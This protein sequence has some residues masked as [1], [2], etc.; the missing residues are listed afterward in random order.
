MVCLF[1]EIFKVRRLLALA[2]GHEKALW[3]DLV[4]LVSNLNVGAVFK[5]GEFVPLRRHC[6]GIAAVAARHRPGPRERMVGGRDLIMQDVRIGLVGIDLLL[7]DRLAILVEGNA[8][9]PVAFAALGVAARQ[10][11]A[12]Q[13]VGQRDVAESGLE[14]HRLRPRFR[15][16]CG[17]AAAGS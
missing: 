5:A 6:R 15:R 2:H 11:E 7:D 4:V 12:L 3:A 17:R 10:V 1:V 13:V 16:G 9:G 8:A 14:R